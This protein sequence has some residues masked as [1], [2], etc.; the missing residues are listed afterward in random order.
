MAKARNHVPVDPLTGEVMD[1]DVAA[2]RAEEIAEELAE[3]NAEKAE[4]RE[5][6]DPLLEQRAAIDKRRAAIENE[7][8]HICPQIARI[9][10]GEGYVV[11]ITPPARKASQTVN[12]RACEIHARDLV[13]L[14]V[15]KWIEKYDTPTAAELKKHAVEIVSAGLP[16]DELLPEPVP[17]LPE[18]TVV[19]VTEAS[20]APAGV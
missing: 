4:L 11:T 10:A 8:R 13:R 16:F 5:T 9:P 7:L 1:P 17:A 15:G 3:L 14:G 6:L 20:E 19:A 2:R 18:V 12:G